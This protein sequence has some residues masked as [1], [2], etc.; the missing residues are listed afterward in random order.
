MHASIT[1][2]G[3]DWNQL[4]S[5]EATVDSAADSAQTVF[6]LPQTLFS[7]TQRIFLINL[8]LTDASGKVISRNF[9]W[10]PYRLTDFDFPATT[11]T[12]TPAEFYPD[13]HALTQLPPATVMAHAEME[14]TSRGS[15]I[16]LQLKNTSNALAF[17]LRFV[18]RT[19]SGGL[20]AP[21]IWS[22]DWVELTP[23]ESRTF[24]TAILPKDT[25]ANA[26]VLLSGWNISS[27]TI[28]PT[29]S[30]GGSQF[31]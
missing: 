19:Q 9:Y 17:Q 7:G 10:V 30:A 12:H 6:T 31:Q 1:V 25:P 24:T 20:I 28:T 13:L 18:L 16:R 8:K 22:D 29:L 11:Y 14:H 26:V 21:V 5:A 15:R 23:G 3:I 27:A 2:H 4:Y